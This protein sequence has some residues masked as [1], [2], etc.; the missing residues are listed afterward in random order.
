MNHCVLEGSCPA[1][2]SHKDEACHPQRAYSLGGSH[3]NNDKS[4]DVGCTM[5]HIVSTVKVTSH[6]AR[7]ALRAARETTVRSAWF[8][9][10]F[11]VHLKLV[12]HG[13][14]CKL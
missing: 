6:G 1:R 13:I 9:G 12:R 3:E 14:E 8:S 4:R 10:H 2:W 7:R 11:A 5:G